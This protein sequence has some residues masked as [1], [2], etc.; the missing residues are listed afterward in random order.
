MTV[1]QDYKENLGLKDHLGLKVL[2][3]I[4]DPLDSPGREESPALKALKVNLELMDR[5]AAMDRLARLDLRGHLVNQAKLEC[6]AIL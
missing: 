5:K 6:L 1:Q 4:P 3:E 2:K